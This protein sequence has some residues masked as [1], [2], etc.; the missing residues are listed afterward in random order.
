MSYYFVIQTYITSLI[1]L[2]MCQNGDTVNYVQNSIL[3]QFLIYYQYI[4]N[5]HDV[6]KNTQVKLYTC[7]LIPHS[8]Y[9]ISCFPL[10]DKILP[11]VPALHKTLSRPYLYSAAQ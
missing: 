3:Y 2:K 9:A 4:F 1:L 10:A 5:A 6:Q 8:M 11:T 7:I